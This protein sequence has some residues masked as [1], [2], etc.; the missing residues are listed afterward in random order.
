VAVLVSERLR[1]RQWTDEDREPL[2][3][4]NADPEVMRHFPACLTR[5]ES[6]A[7]LERMRTHID[8]KGFGFWAAETRDTRE[9]VG[10]AGL[11]TVK[12]IMPFAP[13]VEVGW[14]LAKA[15]WGRGYA[16]EAA[17]AAIGHGFDALALREIVAMTAK[18]N[19]ASQAVMARLGMSRSAAFEHP[20][21]AEASP[22]RPHW[23]YRLSRDRIAF[24]CGSLGAREVV[25]ADL[26]RLQR[27]YED[28]P[29]YFIEVEGAPP[30]PDAARETLHALPP[31]EWPFTRKLVLAFRPADGAIA[32][33]ADVIADLFS[34]G[35]WHLG[36]FMTA[37]RL[38]RSGASRALYGHLERWMRAQGARW[39]RLGVVR[40]NARAERFWERSGYVDVL[41][42]RDYPQGRKRHTLRVMAK[43]L[44]G[45]TL[46][47]YRELVPRD[48]AAATS[49]GSR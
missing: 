28:N 35:V 23:L 11:V 7:M 29:G 48:R 14:R 4:L 3:R 18:S 2:A 49:I 34:P 5:G 27:F 22:V 45:G 43:A 33:V 39:L 47:E 15:H 32:G 21:I 44:S 9:F 6:D 30:G 41:E 24:E 25:H 1:L 40:G 20:A 31:M 26:P 12:D 10:M 42:R 16:T 37:D 13:G 19:L 36:L 8:A 46:D 17:R 38:H